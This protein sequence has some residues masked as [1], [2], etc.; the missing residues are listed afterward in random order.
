VG[1]PDGWNTLVVRT[2]RGREIWE[3]VSDIFAIGTASPEEVENLS[4][5][6]RKMR[7]EEYKVVLPDMKEIYEKVIE[8]QK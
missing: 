7:F 8:A 6:K 1:S 2:E 4:A 3:K 5:Y